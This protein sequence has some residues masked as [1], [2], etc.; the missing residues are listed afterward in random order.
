ML[1]MVV[2]FVEPLFAGRREVDN[3]VKNMHYN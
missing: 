1:E 3:C 2:L